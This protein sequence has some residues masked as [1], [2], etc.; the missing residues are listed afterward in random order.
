MDDIIPPAQNNLTADANLVQS[1]LNP[2]PA[3]Y[4]RDLARRRETRQWKEE[5][6][7]KKNIDDKW[8]H[9]QSTIRSEIIA[10]HAA[11]AWAGQTLTDAGSVLTRQV[12]TTN[13]VV[14]KKRLF[15]WTSAGSRAIQA[16]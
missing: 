2:I 14:R 4:R 3:S 13:P 11:V 15:V 16:S 10:R 1:L 5:E 6:Q 7:A 12:L 9:S 8:S